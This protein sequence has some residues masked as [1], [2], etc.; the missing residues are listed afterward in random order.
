[1][2]GFDRGCRTMFSRYVPQG[3]CH[4]LT[5]GRLVEKGCRVWPSLTPVC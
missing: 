1:M 3:G 2:C 4:G 5:P